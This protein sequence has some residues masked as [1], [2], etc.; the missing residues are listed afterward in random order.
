MAQQ[1]EIRLPEG[2][3][4]M[5]SL[6][7]DPIDFDIVFPDDRKVNFNNTPGKG[8]SI[9]P[10]DGLMLQATDEPVVPDQKPAQ[11]TTVSQSSGGGPTIC[12]LV[13]KDGTIPMPRISLVAAQ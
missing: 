8:A 3:K 12:Y 2:L 7:G 9:K 6:T 11:R 10:M 1:Y 13:N 4:L 5:V